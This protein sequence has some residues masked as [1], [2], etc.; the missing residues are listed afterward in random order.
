VS[1]GTLTDSET[2]TITVTETNRP[3]TVSAGTD[4][5]VTL[6]NAAAL[7][8]TAADP[9]GQA[10]TV[11]WTKISGPGTVTFGSASAVDTTAIFSA[12]GSYVLRLTVSDGAAS[13]S[14]EVSVTA[15]EA[16]DPT[17]LITNLRV[18]T[19]KAVR[20]RPLTLDRDVYIDR[21]YTFQTIPPALEGM[22]YV[23]AANEDKYRKDSSY[24]TFTLTAPATV[25]VAFDVRANKLPSWL[26]K[27]SWVKTGMQLRTSDALFDI[28]ERSYAAGPVSLGGNGALWGVNPY[29]HYVV[30]VAPAGGIATPQ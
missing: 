3:P 23:R 25:Y 11:T 8:G 6:P 27:A 4:L 19:N 15:Q 9:D 18:A 14:D 7:D 30:I 16:F 24:M 10:L 13:I 2:V 5:T 1:D 21:D 20:V 29:S 17:T 22:A 26:A 28:Y 12:A